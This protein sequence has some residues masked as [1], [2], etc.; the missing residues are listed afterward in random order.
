MP[1]SR[2][3]DRSGSASNFYSPLNRWNFYCG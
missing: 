1:N 3:K 2:K